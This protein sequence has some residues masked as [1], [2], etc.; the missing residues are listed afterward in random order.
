MK[1]AQGVCAGG[2]LAVCLLTTQLARATDKLD[3][4]VAMKT[5][6]LLSRALMSPVPVAVVYDPTIPE[7][8]ADADTI[9]SVFDG[10]LEAPGD[11]KMNTSLV[12][13]KALAGLSN[14]KIVFLTHGLSTADGEVVGLAASAAGCLTFCSDIDEVKANNCVIGLTSK[15]RVAV[16]YSPTAAENARISFVPA[17]TMLVKQVDSM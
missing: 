12:D 2:L 9:K 10:G 4:S 8:K 13:I 14:F 1:L 16:Y 5:L 3:L 11:T 15:P 17:F 6:P 7:S